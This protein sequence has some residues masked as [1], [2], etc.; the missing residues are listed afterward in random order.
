MY[1][2]QG[3]LTDLLK[4]NRLVKGHLLQH[5]FNSGWSRSACPQGVYDVR[6]HHSQPLLC[7]RNIWAS[8]A[9]ALADHKPS[10]LAYFIPYALEG[11][12]NNSYLL[13]I[14]EKTR[15]KLVCRTE[16]LRADM[17]SWESLR[18]LALLLHFNPPSMWCGHGRR[19]L[20][21]IGEFVG[22]IRC[23]VFVRSEKQVLFQ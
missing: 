22:Q 21:H 20:G 14:F 2:V 17:N 18:D 7:D 12:L 10:L 1:A 16:Q 23:T 19:H 4:C 11:H 9:S 8:T 15:Q 6:G 13:M 3:N 5:L